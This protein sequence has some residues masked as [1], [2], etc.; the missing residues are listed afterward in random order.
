[1][2]YD[3]IRGIVHYLLGLL[4][5]VCAILYEDSRLSYTAFAVLFAGLAY[6]DLDKV[7]NKNETNQI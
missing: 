1:M 6:H 2:T 3:I 4:F 5:L 7:F